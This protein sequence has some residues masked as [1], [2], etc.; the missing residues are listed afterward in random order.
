M[1]S[2]TTGQALPSP[3]LST[4]TAVMKPE[5]S[6]ASVGPTTGQALPAPSSSTTT[7]V[8][9]LDPPSPLKR[10][11]IGPAPTKESSRSSPFA[12]P[13][14]PMIAN[15]DDASRPLT[16]SALPPGTPNR[17]LSQRSSGYQDSLSY[18]YGWF[19]TLSLAIYRGNSD[20][21]VLR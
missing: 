14:S 5:P 4:P 11:K 17:N 13:A 10:Q 20:I 6:A 15:S 21:F 3:G 8:R 12:R 1:G 7:A 18:S 9:K 2:T 16:V 19:R